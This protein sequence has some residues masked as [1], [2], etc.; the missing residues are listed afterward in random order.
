M[1]FSSFLVLNALYLV[2][3]CAHLSLRDI[4]P[5]TLQ[6]PEAIASAKTQKELEEVAQLGAG[7]LIY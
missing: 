6:L 1:L 5:F 2:F 3:N 4:L 7:S